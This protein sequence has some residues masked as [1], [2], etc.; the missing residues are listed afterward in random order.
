MKTFIAGF[1][2]RIRCITTG[3]MRGLDPRIPLAQAIAHLKGIAGSS[4]AMT[5]VGWR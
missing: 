4:P 3:V 1:L 2:R 5:A